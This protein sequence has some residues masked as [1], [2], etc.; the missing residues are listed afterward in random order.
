MS[1][2]LID[3]KKLSEILGLSKQTIYEMV[4]QSRIPYIKLSSRI[5]RF[6][7]EKIEKWIE[8]KSYEPRDLIGMIDKP[9]FKM[10]KK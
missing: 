8:S 10:R 7:S 3:I 1:N 4:S 2:K 9:L 5:L 6:D